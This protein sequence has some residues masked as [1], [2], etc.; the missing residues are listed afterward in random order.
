[1]YKSTNIEELM[2]VCRNL[3]PF[4][5]NNYERFRKKNIQQQIRDLFYFGPLG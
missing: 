1:M 3:N 4:V 5:Q 2:S